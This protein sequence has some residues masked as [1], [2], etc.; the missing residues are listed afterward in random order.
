MADYDQQ[1]AV[2]GAHDHLV[3]QWLFQQRLRGLSLEQIQGLARQDG[4][5]VTPSGWYD[6][7]AGIGRRM[8]GSTIS[9]RIKAVTTE[10][11]ERNLDAA[12][13]LRAFAA[14][15]LDALE[16]DLHR[17]R[18]R[19]LDRCIVAVAIGGFDVR[20]EAQVLKTDLALVRLEERRAK[21]LGYDMPTQVEHSGQVEVVDA[22]SAE[23][24]ALIEDAAQRA[25]A[26]RA[27]V[28]ES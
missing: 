11:H 1:R 9:R 5:V 13:D 12:A 4:P 3:N 17:Q 8:D 15:K 22:A 6:I 2:A 25:E 28:V 10:H 21:M 24:A 14:A 27:R 26:E 19:A 16:V 7:D 18:Q 23:L 20:A